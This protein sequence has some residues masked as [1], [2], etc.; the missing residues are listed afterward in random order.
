MPKID[1][2]IVDEFKNHL[3]LL[4]ILLMPLNNS[5]VVIAFSST[6]VLSL[7][8][9]FSSQNYNT[10]SLIILLP[11][12]LL[13]L[14]LLSLIYV[15]DFNEGIKK[16]TKNLALILVPACFFF[17]QFSSRQ[18]EKA[19]KIF[20]YSWVL[21][22]FVSLVVLAYNW[23]ELSDERHFYNFIQTSMYHNYMPQDAMYINT[24]LVFLLFG[25]Y[26]S[27]FK[28]LISLLFLSVL[29][30]FSVR[31]GLLTYSF[32]FLIYIS[33]NF[34]KLANAK[35]IIILSVFLFSSFL[36]VNS[37]PY[38]K[39][40]LFD[41]LSKLGISNTESEV[42]EIGEAYHNISFRSK[43]WKTSLD[44]IEEKPVLGYGVGMEKNILL[45]KNDQKGYDFP[46]YHSHNQFLSVTIQYG[47]FGLLIF[48]LVL[49][50]IMR[51]ALG[52]IQL[53][54]VSLILIPSMITDSY[55]DVQ[56]GIF[57]FS[58]FASL[59]LSSKERNQKLNYKN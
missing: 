48:I 55:F 54:L 19:K 36:L 21:F 39:D 6:L 46:R 58:F 42:S 31:L 29:I 25:K 35:N 40:K 44:V 52:D 18:I 15:E 14:S 7:V 57:Y 49:T 59:I 38:T 23:F 45:K 20:L 8:T 43:M 30:L 1:L 11:G 3:F 27:V 32:I 24:A 12:F 5:F 17:G 2:S 51:S 50:I 4:S 41:S 9:F 16:T 10:V 56:Q 22:S 37:N 28:I 26:K 47:V 53:I 34:K 33:I 13:L